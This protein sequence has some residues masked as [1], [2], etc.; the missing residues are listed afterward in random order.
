MGTS[1]SVV[2]T[3]AGRCLTRWTT[4]SSLVRRLEPVLVTWTGDRSNPPSPH[5]AAAER[6][7]RTAVG[8]QSNIAAMVVCPSPGGDPTRRSTSQLT[9]SQCRDR[10]RESIEENDMPSSRSCR[11]ATTPCW[12]SASSTA[13][14]GCD[15]G[16]H[17]GRLWPGVLARSTGS[18]PRWTS[19]A[20]RTHLA[21]SSHGARTPFVMRDPRVHQGLASRNPRRGRRGGAGEEEQRSDDQVSA[22]ASSSSSC[23]VSH[24]PSSRSAVAFATSS[25]SAS[26]RTFA[27]SS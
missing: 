9:S 23:A 24:S 27:W 7:D 19:H 4:A 17:T 16:E 10:A 22:R 13:E 5:H 18:A 11:L 6:C 26:S 21:R 14:Q 12:A 25:A 20:P 15:G 1:R 8:P 3:R 2:T